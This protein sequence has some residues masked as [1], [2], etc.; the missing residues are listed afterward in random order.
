MW[1]FYPPHSHSNVSAVCWQT[2]GLS[3]PS[4]SN[5]WEQ[6]SLNTVSWLSSRTLGTLNAS[7][8]SCVTRLTNRTDPHLSI[9]LSLVDDGQRVSTDDQLSHLAVGAHLAPG[10]VLYGAGQREHCGEELVTDCQHSLS[11]S[12]KLTQIQSLN[13]LLIP[14]ETPPNGDLVRNGSTQGPEPLTSGLRSAGDQ[15]TGANR[16]SGLTGRAEIEAI[17]TD[18]TIKQPHSSQSFFDRQVQ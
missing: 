18:I 9:G 3:W 1:I 4:G 6:P 7:Q 14:G 10:I 2:Q 17:H 15:I 8:W 11:D 16:P 13:I 12:L 5:S